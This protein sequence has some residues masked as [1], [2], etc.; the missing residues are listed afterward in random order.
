[1]ENN[2]WREIR[3]KNGRLLFKFHPRKN[4]IEQKRGSTI[5]VIDLDDGTVTERPATAKS[6]KQQLRNL[7]QLAY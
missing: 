7:G 4:Q 6:Y 5:H 2:G 3:T 1:M